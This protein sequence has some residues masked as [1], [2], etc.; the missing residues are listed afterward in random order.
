M[1]VKSRT[2]QNRH[3][4]PPEDFQCL[5]APAASLA[6]PAAL[7]P[8]S[9]E[10]VFRMTVLLLSRWA[11]ARGAPR[12]RALHLHRAEYRC[13]GVGFHYETLRT[14]GNKEVEGFSTG[15]RPADSKGEGGGSHDGAGKASGITCIRRQR[16]RQG[17][18]RQRFK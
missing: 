9:P 17:S 7:L 15:C 3:C 4:D 5:L 8:R 13:N 1:I 6:G 14:V 18:G 16:S 10:K 2:R 11:F 12:D